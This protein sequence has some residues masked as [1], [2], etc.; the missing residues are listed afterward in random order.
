MTELNPASTEAAEETVAEKAAPVKNASIKNLADG[1]SDLYRLAPSK[2]SVKEGFNSRVKD[3]DP[4]DADDIALAKSI[5]VHGIKQPLAVFVEGA[6]AVGDEIERLAAQLVA[7]FTAPVLA[8][9][10]PDIRALLL[11]AATICFVGELG[12]WLWPTLMPLGWSLILGFGQGAEGFQEGQTLHPCRHGGGGQRGDR[13]AHRV[14]EDAEPVPAQCIGSVENGVQVR[15]QAVLGPRGQMR[16]VTVAGKVQ[17]EQVQL[18]QVRQQ[19]QETGGV[20]QPAVQRDEPGA[21][22]A[23]LAQA[24]QFAESDRHRHLAQA[25]ASR[26]AAQRARR[27]SASACAGAS[28]RQGM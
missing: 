3:F 8:D 12:I 11:G 18:R 15:G 28:L 10:V 24:C 13:R 19:R 27:A 7:G 21:T 4:A 6:G 14:A 25:H 5:A 1:R 26:P 2:L 16:A 20:V 23:L 9:R 17:Q 22:R